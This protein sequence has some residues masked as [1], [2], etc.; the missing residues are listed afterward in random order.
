MNVLWF[1]NGIMPGYLTG[2]GK[3]AGQAITGCWTPA[4]LD[5]LRRFAP[6]VRLSVAFRTPTP[7]FTQVDGVDYYGLGDSAD[8]A[9]LERVEQCVRT[10]RPDV[11]H[12][13]GAEAMAQVL[14][15]ALLSSGKVVLSLQG[16][17]EEVAKSYLGGLTWADMKPFENI[18]R[19]LF[20]RPNEQQIAAAWK[21]QRAPRE[22]ELCRRISAFMGR[23]R[24]DRDWIRRVNPAA[25]YFHVDEILRP[26]FYQGRAW[27][28]EPGRHVI[29][30]GAAFTYPLK[31]GHWLL[32]AL[33]IV[34]ESYP[35]VELR[36]AASRRCALS[37]W[38]DRV[39]LGAYGY[40][41]VH[42]IDELGL[43]ENVTFLPALSAQEVRNELMHANVYCLAS[44]MEN[45][46]NSLC[47]AQM[48]GTPAV[49]TRVGGVEDLVTDGETG[50]VVPPRDPDA[51]AE[52][53]LKIFQMGPKQAEKMTDGA[54]KAAA[55]RHDPQNIVHDVVEAYRAVEGKK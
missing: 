49:A 18:V 45:S 54:Y 3:K 53:I 44:T 30:A 10:A 11:I 16:I 40:Y 8:G 17:M 47:E 1:T 19:R 15:D 9:F 32:R 5:A 13:H 28:A 4:L 33:K 37:N 36:I 55:R 23:T 42:L 26:E 14:P 21:T 25:A 41:L 27:A 43:R 31:G 39:R 24:F 51:L 38:I 12:I 46:P 34:K 35:D 50:F 48:T 20:R 7:G 22:R 6:D 52:A 2:L 29:Y